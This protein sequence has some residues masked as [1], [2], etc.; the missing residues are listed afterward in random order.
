MNG[1]LT[2]AR[3]VCGDECSVFRDIRVY[4]EAGSTDSLELVKMRPGNWKKRPNDQG[5]PRCSRDTRRPCIRCFRFR[6]CSWNNS[7][8]SFFA[9]AIS[10][11]A[12]LKALLRKADQCSINCPSYMNCMY[13]SL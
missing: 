11:T 8:E 12:T 3:E 7:I 4:T 5:R 1:K 2:E 9:C 6:L 10:S 13:D